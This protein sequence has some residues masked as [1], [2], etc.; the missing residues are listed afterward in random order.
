[1]AI[2]TEHAPGAP[3]WFELA[4]SDQEAGKKFYMQ[5]FGWTA[6]DNPMGPDGVYTMFQ[7]D[8]HDAG[9]AYTL[10]KQLAEQGVPPHWNVYFSVVSADESA[11]K[12]AALG[13]QIV[14]PP[15]DVMEHG[16]MSII[17]DP[18]GAVFSIWQPNKHIGATV[19]DQDNAQCWA[20]LA[21]W[22]AP[23]MRDFYS[24]LFGW[25]TRG[26]ANM[27]TYIEFSAAGRF[28]GG[29]LAMDEKWK[30][31]PSHWSLYF[32]VADCAATMDKAKELGAEVIFGPHEAPGVGRFGALHDPQGAVFSVIQLAAPT[33]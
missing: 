4:T 17:R 33:P 28:R 11:A 21:T 12:A 15:F 25:E 7:L 27:P 19:I 24:G 6:I 18:G 2:V 23:R 1:M 5:L 13:G 22:D 31:A 20:E 8:G 32:Q 3:C 30:G 29:L 10:P 9:A 26:A 16:C 14:Q